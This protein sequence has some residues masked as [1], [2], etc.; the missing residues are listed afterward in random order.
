[1]QKAAAIDRRTAY[2][3]CLVSSWTRRI[4]EC[5]LYAVI[6]ANDHDKPSAGLIR[7]WIADIMEGGRKGAIART[8]A[9]H[10]RQLWIDSF[11]PSGANPAYRLHEL[12]LH[13]PFLSSRL[14]LFPN[15]ESIGWAQRRNA[16]WLWKEIAAFASRLPAETTE[17]DETLARTR[18]KEL[19]VTVDFKAV[20]LHHYSPI[21]PT[22]VD[23]IT[24]LRI[25]HLTEYLAPNSVL[26]TYRSLTHLSMATRAA[27]GEL[28]VNSHS[29]A[30]PT[31]AH[32]KMHVIELPQK[33][34]GS[35]GQEC[36]REIK[37]Q[38]ARGYPIFAVMQM[39]SL[40][41]DW[42]REAS[43]GDSIWQR[44]RTFASALERQNWEYDFD[45]PQAAS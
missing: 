4:A 35:Q 9:G 3:L 41:D 12:Y 17:K 43:G 45:N 26:A 36:L 10:V 15:L 5:H 8:R 44:A 39:A 37:M 20:S 25:H 6:I 1:M 40:H 22:S 31:F 30:A 28:L 23:A 7:R 16:I 13:E 2:N 19:H 38:R 14:L 33:G 32:L 42:E 11:Y 27:T 34:S 21:T 24:H 29:L 18:R